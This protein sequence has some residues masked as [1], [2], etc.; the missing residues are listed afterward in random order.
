MT[1]CGLCG[2]NHEGEC[3]KAFDISPVDEVIFEVR[4][5]SKKDPTKTAP[6]KINGASPSAYTMFK[7]SFLISLAKII[8]ESEMHAE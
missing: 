1:Q 7:P 2:Y 3:Q 8:R 5:R 4:I 6:V